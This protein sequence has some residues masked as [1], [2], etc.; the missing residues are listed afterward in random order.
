MRASLLMILMAR[1]PSG[2]TNTEGTE[3]EGLLSLL[4][5]TQLI[6]DPANFQSLLH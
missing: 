6:V 5:L 2:D 4:H 1:W 3:I